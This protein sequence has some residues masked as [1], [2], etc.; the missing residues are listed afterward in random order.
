MTPFSWVFGDSQQ[1]VRVGIRRVVH[2]TGRP[3][4]QISDEYHRIA[5]DLAIK[6]THA[7]GKTNKPTRSK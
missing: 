5:R 4:I 2:K 6:M 1:V 3:V 7:E